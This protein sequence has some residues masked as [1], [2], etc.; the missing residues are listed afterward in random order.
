MSIRNLRTFVA[1]SE[2]GSFAAAAERIF[3]THAAVSVQIQTLERELGVSLFDRTHRPAQLTDA[4]KA[5]V[6]MAVDLIRTFDRLPSA[7]RSPGGEKFHFSLGAIPSSLTTVTPRVLNALRQ[8]FPQLHID[9]TNRTSEELIQMVEVGSI[10][11]AFVSH[12]PE[13]LPDLEWHPF[14]RDPLVVLAPTN[15]PMFD[16]ERLLAE[17][18]FIHLSRDMWLG[19]MIEN[20]LRTR[21]IQ[22]REIM[23][24]DTLEAVASMVTYGL[25]VAIA[26]AQRARPSAKE[27]FRIVPLPRP[28]VYRTLG[29][30]FRSAR[31]SDPLIMTL[32]ADLTSFSKKLG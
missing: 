30:A 27:K 17:M 23:T 11:A 15:A 8:R 14:V 1:I 16:A 2:T 26:P 24:L 12:I 6:P 7:L 18:P 5:L 28:T 13:P 22:V 21:R 25:G 9:L 31:K 29:L 32:L 4:G 19:R 3:L 20:L 10:D